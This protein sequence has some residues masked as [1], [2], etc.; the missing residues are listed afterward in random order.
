M[1]LGHCNKIKDDLALNH[2]GKHTFMK[3]KFGSTE[4][5]QVQTVI[6]FSNCTKITLEVQKLICI[7][8]LFMMDSL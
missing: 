5:L 4:V 1:I 8:L 3:V 2:D 6:Y 7:I